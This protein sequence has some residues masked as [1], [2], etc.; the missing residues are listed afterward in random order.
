MSRTMTLGVHNRL[1]CHDRFRPDSSEQDSRHLQLLSVVNWSLPKRPPQDPVRPA[2]PGE[3]AC[4]SSC[5]NICLMSM[6]LSAIVRPTSVAPKENP[7]D[8]FNSSRQVAPQPT[9]DFT[10]PFQRADLSARWA[11]RAPPK[12]QAHALASAVGGSRG[13]YALAGIHARAVHRERAL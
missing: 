10:K 9:S 13:V 8:V 2:S 12:R 1:R 7:N 3:P 4:E 11:D 5:A 6:T